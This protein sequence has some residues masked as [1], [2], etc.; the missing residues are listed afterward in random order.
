MGF[1]YYCDYCDK[2]FIDDVEA[3]KKHLNCVYHLKMKKLHYASFRGKYKDFLNESYIIIVH[4]LLDLSEI[5][6]EESVKI[7]CNR[8]KTAGYCQF[9]TSCKY[10]HYTQEQLWHIKEM[11]KSSLN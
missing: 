8:F 3:R 11:S 7:P 1:R 5:L 10:T 4:L 6:A 9:E 2:V